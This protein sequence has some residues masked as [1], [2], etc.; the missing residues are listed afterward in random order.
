MFCFHVHEESDLHTHGLDSRFELLQR[1]H[2]I[3]PIKPLPYCI[4]S[5]IQHI[6]TA[7]MVP[8]TYFRTQHLRMSRLLA[9]P[10]SCSVLVLTR[11]YRLVNV[12]KTASGYINAG[13]NSPSALWKSHSETTSVVPSPLPPIAS[14]F[15]GLCAPFILSCRELSI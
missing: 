2:F 15:Y 14:M 9:Q 3:L 6:Q 8:N 11:C 1:S 10:E 13:A 7:D 5:L 4:P 12:G